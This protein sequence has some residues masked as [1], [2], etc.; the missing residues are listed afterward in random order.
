MDRL[1]RQEIEGVAE[2]VIREL[3]IVSLPVDPRL[4]AEHRGITVMP[5]D[6]KEAGV[7]GFLVKVG[8]NFG[9]LHAAHLE[10]EGFIRFTIA[11]ELGHYFIPGHVELLFTEGSTL[12]ASRSGFVSSLPHE[13]EADHFAANLLMPRKLF[14]PAL[15]RA[16][17]GFPAIES[18]ATLCRTS[19]TATAI[20]YATFADDPV[21]V[22]LSTSD[23]VDFCVLSHALKD[24]RRVEWIKKGSTLP[25]ESA[26]RKYNGGQRASD[27]LGRREDSTTLDLWM[28]GAPEAEVNEDVVGLGRYGKTLTVLWSEEAIEAEAGDDDDV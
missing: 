20:R 13:Q 1:R 19:I 6:S 10:N 8:D 7:S 11:H 23:R 9:I 15:R 14:L 22:I 28:D 2:D 21:A 24:L 4:I 17:R 26:T 25:Q 5:K 12:H 16:G 27:P 18:L 3:E